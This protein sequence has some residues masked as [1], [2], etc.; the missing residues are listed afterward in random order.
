[1]NK[2]RVYL[3]LAAL[4]L[5]ACAGNA[6]NQEAGAPPIRNVLVLMS[7][8]HAAYATGAYGN[9]IIRT[10]SIDRLAGEGVLFSRAYA[11]SP[12]C[13]PSRHSIITGRLPHAAGVTL[14]R[15]SL[16]ED[17]LTIAEHLQSLGFKTGAVGKMAFYGDAKHGFDYRIEGRDHDRYLEA[18][19][20]QRPPTDT[21][22]KAVWKPFRDPAATWLNSQ[23]LPG[24]GYPAPGNFERRGLY[25]NDFLGTFFASLAVDFMT[26]N[27]NERFCLWLSFYEPHSPFNFPI[28]FA[29]RYNPAEMPVPETGAEDERWI[30]EIF[31]DLT[32]QEKRGIIRSYYSSVE[33]LDK[34][35]GQTLDVLK[36]LGLD[37]N[38]LVVYVSDHGYLLGHH[39]RFEKH[40]MWEEA[41][42]VPLIIRDPRYPSRTVNALVELID[43]VPTILEALG[44]PPMP[45][46]QGK[47]LRHLLRGGEE[48]HRDVVFSEYL[49]D[50]RAMVRDERWKYVITSGKHDL[51]LGYATGFGPSGRFETLYDLQ[52]DPGEFHNLAGDPDRS[53][54]LSEMRARMLEVFQS[55]HP[56]AGAMP[57]GLS[58]LGK[59]EWFLEP[60]DP[61]P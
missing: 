24:T 27:R 17:Q 12:V 48:K 47:S 42:R 26:R 2:A 60:P 44:V 8:D 54:V 53:E 32:E 20:A 5:S 29:G 46:Q 56:N 21:P 4:L 35:I 49:D 55:T 43:L 45:G 31:R 13:S 18:H 28:E 23:G 22:T 9:P 3:A 40:S 41:V 34:N 52:E 10:P 61:T 59:L 1:M 37:R 11:N 19:P 51:A 16:S 30:P 38:T 36:D 57:P 6:G 39:G 25:D 7:D 14:L 50:H 15:S 58:I 33:Y